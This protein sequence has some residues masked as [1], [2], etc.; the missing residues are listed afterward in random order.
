MAKAKTK[1]PFESPELDKDIA[2]GEIS[3]DQRYMHH[4]NK[5]EL[6]QLCN[7]VSP[8]SRAHR[9]MDRDELLTILRTRRGKGKS[10]VDRYRK[11]IRAF[12]EVNWKKIQDQIDPKCNGNCYECHDVVVLS[13]YVV[14]A[15]RL[16]EF[17]SKRAIKEK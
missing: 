16:Q 1:D 13:C 8:N 10:I 6:V 3:L 14:N 7:L 2:S 12:L 17:R 11:L 5:S 15:K 9:G 4:V